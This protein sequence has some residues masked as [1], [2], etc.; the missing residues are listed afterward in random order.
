VL[1]VLLARPESRLYQRQIA[2]LAGLRLLQ[3]QRALRA[4][5]DL[6]VLLAQREGNRV[7]YSPDPSCPI[8]PELTAMVLK[9][10]GLA[11]VLQEALTGVEGI[12]LAFIFGS[13]AKGTGDA[14]SDVDVLIV[15]EAS[16][17]DISA[18]LL[19][20]Q[21]RLGREVTPTVY[22]PEEFSERLKTKH[23]FL[24][25]V[26]KEPKIMLIGTPDDLERMGRTAS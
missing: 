23:H 11:D 10:A 5:A 18:A 17:A 1:S 22:S 20:A 4:L 3:A 14:K 13:M 16:F 15:G 8:L 2:Q 19:S 12:A 21:E 26:L 24:M 6:G 7:Y 25:R 9:T